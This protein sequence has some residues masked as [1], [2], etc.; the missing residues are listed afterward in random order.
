MIEDD[1]KKALLKLF[2]CFNVNGSEA[3]R[4]I[5]FAAY[6]DMLRNLPPELIVSTCARAGRGEIGNRGF[7]PSTAELYQAVVAQ[8]PRRIDKPLEIAASEI[9][10]AEKENVSTLI[11]E[12]AA[13]MKAFPNAKKHDAQRYEQHL[14]SGD[15]EAEL[16]AKYRD[17]P[18]PP[19]SAKLRAKLGVGIPEIA[20]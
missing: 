8:L 4:K 3:E 12:L 15:L 16:A 14:P 7:L 1:A 6:W 19:L 9:S 11:R 13:G 5:K 10:W 2:Q 17:K 18:L 20:E